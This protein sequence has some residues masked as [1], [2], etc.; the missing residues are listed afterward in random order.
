MLVVL[1]ILLGGA[2]LVWIDR[3]GDRDAYAAAEAFLQGNLR[4]REVFGPNPEVVRTGGSVLG[5]QVLNWNGTITGN[6]VEAVVRVGMNRPTQDTLWTATRAAYKTAEGEWQPM[7]ERQPPPSPPAAPENA[8]SVVAERAWR[9]L[10]GARSPRLPTPGDPIPVLDHPVHGHVRSL[11]REVGLEAALVFADSA[12][13]ILH[14]DLLKS[15][16][17]AAAY[18]AAGSAGVGA[19]LMK[20]WIQRNG[21]D[22][23][24]WT[25]L[26]R[27]YYD[28]GAYLQAIDATH[29]AVAANPTNGE[30]LVT[31]G[32][33]YFKLRDRSRALE[34]Y[35][36][37]CELQST[38]GCELERSLRNSRE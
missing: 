35:R 24:A 15:Y 3:K 19:E 17:R 27:L 7:H 25:G 5:S 37:A 10:R 11:S 31:A 32:L 21:S 2:S 28:A 4:V 12:A 29:N 16:A 14:N 1:A 23:Q 34:S 22:S 13:R 36:R 8:E 26:A 30:A 9:F 33:T 18:Q 20:Q 38:A 6:G